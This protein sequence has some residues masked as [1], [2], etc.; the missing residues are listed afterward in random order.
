M[1]AHLTL[2]VEG[3][4]RERYSAGAQT[5]E[6]ALCCPVNY[7][8][9]FL[10]VIPQ[11]VLDRDYG[12]GDPS[13]HL[14]AGETVLDL[15]S[16]GGKI[17]FIASQVVGSE[18]KVI[19][20]D[21]N[22]E[23]LALAKSAA[24]KVA[25][26]IGYSNVDFK[27]GRI[28]DLALDMAELETWLRSHPVRNAEDL[29][30]MESEMRRLRATSSLVA[31]ESVD[32][33]VS[34]CVLNLV[35]A[36]DKQQ[37]FREI[38]RVLKRGGRA[39]ISDIVSDQDVPMHLQNDAELWSGCLSGAFQEEAFLKA[40]EQ[41]GFYGITLEKRDSNPW[42]VV[43]GIEFRS[44]TIIAYK[45]KEGA[46]MDHEQA[47][48]YKGPWKQ[49]LDDDGHVLERGV[50]TAVCAKTFELYGREPYAEAFERLEPMVAIKP[51]DAKPFDCG[52]SASRREVSGLKGLSGNDCG[53]DC[54]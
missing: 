38:H 6:S 20:V 3:A 45:G 42:R 28:Q 39:V 13:R 24:P 15:G 49:V 18:G 26:A 54:C 51:E 8:P 21:M 47:V 35:A 43:E 36:E 31:S 37:L 33:V 30:K 2:D 25:D 9:Q 46:C 32:V 17:A 12:C 10:K 53:P 4:V 7:D 14:K 19:G 29:G 5:Q 11:D 23:M 1:N 44:V 40:F 48:I 27:K 16:G 50:P 52:P 22:E 34:N 41:A